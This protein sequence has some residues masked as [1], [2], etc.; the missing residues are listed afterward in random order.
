MV[1]NISV[2][3]CVNIHVIQSFDCKAF[4]VLNDLSIHLV[5]T[6]SIVKR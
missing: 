3:Y 1:F 5:C 6:G 4:L 2:A